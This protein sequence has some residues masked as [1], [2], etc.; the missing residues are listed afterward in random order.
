MERWGRDLGVRT[1]RAFETVLADIRSGLDREIVELL[2]SIE[3][4]RAAERLESLDANAAWLVA[5]ELQRWPE[6]GRFEILSV[7]MT[8]IPAN[9]L[10]TEWFE[11]D[12][13]VEDLARAWVRSRGESPDPIGTPSHCRG[14]VLAIEWL[15]RPRVILDIALDEGDVAEGMQL[16]A[17]G[18]ELRCFRQ[19]YLPTERRAGGERR[20]VAARLGEVG[21][22]RAG[23]EVVGAWTSSEPVSGA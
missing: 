2:A 9:K 16:V 23:A 20:V 17:G 18:M 3:P 4:D 8:T 5:R 21:E 13:R 6:G 14:R 19:R 11:V 10:T 15:R 7:S 12:R 1:P 22:L